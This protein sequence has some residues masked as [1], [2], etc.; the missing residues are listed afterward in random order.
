MSAQGKFTSHDQY[1]KAAPKAIQARLQELRE[2]I[3]KAAPEAEEVI[4][5]NMPAFKLFGNLVYYAANK[6]HVGFYPGDS[7][8]TTLFKD[9][10]DKYTT[11]KGAIH[12]PIDKPIPQALVKKIVKNRIK[13]NQERAAL[14][15]LSK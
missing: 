6:A 9:E 11:T 15:K 7:T 4:S 10:L 12:F 2:V 8:T 5:Y 14:K 3:L 1:I 13:E